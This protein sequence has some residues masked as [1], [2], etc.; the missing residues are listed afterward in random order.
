MCTGN[1]PRVPKSKTTFR[2]NKG[3]MD[4]KPKMT[5]RTSNGDIDT[6]ART[7]LTPIKN[8]ICMSKEDMETWSKM[9]WR[10]KQERHWSQSKDDIKGREWGLS[11][12]DICLRTDTI[13]R[14]K[15]TIRQ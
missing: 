15:T 7:T 13:R 10:P 14:T 9:T 4:T 6:K 3:D 2:T 12:D 5:L 1:I 11:K 8:Y